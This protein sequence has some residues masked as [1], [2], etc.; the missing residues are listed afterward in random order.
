MPNYWNKAKTFFQQFRKGEFKKR[1]IPLS[2]LDEAAIVSESTPEEI[3]AAKHFPYLQ[4]VGLL[5]YPASQCK[6]EI[7]YAV[8]LVGSKRS[9]WTQKHFDIVIKIFEYALT[10]CEIGLIFSTGLDPHGIM[11]Y[12]LLQMRITDF[13]DHKGVTT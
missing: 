11:C 9:G 13:R 3:V 1:Q 8:S 5:S 10:T 2:V 6:F 4:A 7:S 12:M